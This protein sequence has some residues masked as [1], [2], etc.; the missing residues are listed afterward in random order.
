MHWTGQTN[1]WQT[2]DRGHSGSGEAWGGAILISPWGLLILWCCL[3][4]HFYH[5]ILCC[6]GQTERAPAHPHLLLISHDLQRNCLQFV[7]EEPHAPCKANLGPNLTRLSSQATTE[8]WFTG[9]AES[10]PRTNSALKIFW[11]GCSL[12]IWQSYSTTTDSDGTVMYNLAMVGLRMSRYSIPHVIISVGAL[13]KPGQKWS[14]V[15]A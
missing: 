8:L 11:R 3:W 15:T 2:N 7:C 9:C 4:T 13:T 12:T 14:R 10:T 6:I 1:R 5:K